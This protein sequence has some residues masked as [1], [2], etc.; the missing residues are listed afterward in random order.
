[1]KENVGSNELLGMERPAVDEAEP[2]FQTQLEWA[3]PPHWGG[4]LL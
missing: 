3:P 1:M 2:H 4:L